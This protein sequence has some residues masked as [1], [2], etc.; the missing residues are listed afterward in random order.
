VHWWEHYVKGMVKNPFTRAGSERNSNRN[1]TEK[2]LYEAIDEVLQKP[3]Q[4]K[5]KITALKK[6]ES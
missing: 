2:F 1:R 6:D 3:I 5:Q 4:Q